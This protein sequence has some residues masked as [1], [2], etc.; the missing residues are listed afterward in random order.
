MKNKFFFIAFTIAYLSLVM[1][2]CTKEKTTE[3]QQQATEAVNVSKPTP[4]LGNNSGSVVGRIN[5]AM[6]TTIMLYNQATASVHGPY[7]TDPGTGFFKISSLPAGI[8]K[9]VITYPVAGGPNGTHDSNATISI[10]IT[11]S[12]KTITDVGTINL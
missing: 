12:S 1:L 9:L 6:K 5:P 11:V 2:S 10:E 7:H 3:L 4:I 8:Y